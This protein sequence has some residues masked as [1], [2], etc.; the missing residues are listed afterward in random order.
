MNK[1]LTPTELTALFPVGKIVELLPDTRKKVAF[2]LEMAESIFFI[3]NLLHDTFDDEEEILPEEI[4][5]VVEKALNDTPLKAMFSF[6]LGE[7]WTSSKA[8]RNANKVSRGMWKYIWALIYADL[9]K[10]YQLSWKNYNCLLLTLLKKPTAGGVLVR[11]YDFETEDID[12]DIEK[13]SDSCPDFPPL[14]L[15]K[16]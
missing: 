15:D 12:P 6:S 11:G 1:D 7:E 9:A 5:S 3:P 13:H 8:L 2:V 16:Q 4:Q 14:D 10:T